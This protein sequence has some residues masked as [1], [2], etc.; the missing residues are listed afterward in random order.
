MGSNIFD[1]LAMQYVL[2][3]SDEDTST[4]QQAAIAIEKPAKSTPAGDN[5]TAVRQWVASINRWMPNG[6]IDDGEDDIIARAQALNFL[7]KTLGFLQKDTLRAD[8]V[9]LLISFFN[10]L[11]S[12]DHKA[13]IAASAKALQQ[14]VTM[15]TFKPS[16]G[17]DIIMN[18]I[19]LGEDFKRQ[20]PAT[21]LEIYELILALLLDPLVA[22]DLSYQHGNTCG[23]MTALVDLCK[24]ERDPQ[25]LI[26]W[27]QIQRLFLQNFAPTDEVTVEVFKAF[28]GYFPITLR[29]SATPSGITVE[30]LKRAVRS[31]FAA[32][33][34]IANLAV[35]FLINKLDQGEAVSVS[36]K[37]DIL[38][39]L[40]ACLRQYEHVKQGIVPYADQ[41][42][43]SLKYE[44]RNGEIQDTI[45]A[46]LKAIGTL[47]NRLDEEDLQAF[48]ATAWADLSEDLAN[49]TY[50]A[51][52]GR[53]LTAIAGSSHKS[54]A[55]TS[56]PAVAQITDT[57][58]HS[59]STSHQAELLTLLNAMLLVRSAFTRDTSGL[60][61]D[62]LFGN[63][64]FEGIYGRLWTEW[65]QS[66][67][68]TE[69]LSVMYKL[70]DG[71][72]Y[73]T[74]QSTSDGSN[75]RLCSDDVC[76]RIFSW[77]GKPSI[78]CR[79]E[80]KRFLQGSLDN[81]QEEL[82]SA[83][84]LALARVAPS[85]PAGFQQ[86][87]VQFLN[88]I[89]I[90]AET[91]I[92]SLIHGEAVREA[93]KRLAYIGC[94]ATACG[95][96]PIANFV[97]LINALLEG[98]HRLLRVSPHFWTPLIDSIHIAIH[99]SLS[100]LAAKLSDEKL[101]EPDISP[102]TTTEGRE[103]FSGFNSQVNGLPE[104]DQDVLG[105]LDE[106][107]ESL[108]KLGRD[109]SLAYQQ[110]L[111][112]SLFVMVQLYRRFVSLE[113]IESATADTTIGTELIIKDAVIHLS[114]EFDGFNSLYST[115]PQYRYLHQL[116]RLATTVI[117]SF[118]AN[119]QKH[120]RLDENVYLLFQGR[121]K[122][123]DGVVQ[124][125]TLGENWAVIK[126]SH[127]ADVHQ[128]AP[129]VLG[130]IQGLWPTVLEKVYLHQT[131][132][133]LCLILA[134]PDRNVS[135]S[136]RASLDTILTTLSNKFIRSDDLVVDWQRSFT[137]LADGFALV[138]RRAGGG[139]P[140][141]RASLAIIRSIM[142]FLSG[143]ITNYSSGDNANWLL[144][145]V[146]DSLPSEITMGRQLAQC[147]EI[148]V[149]EKE[150]LKKENHALVK[151]L[152]RQWIYQKTV[153][154]Y[155]DR[156]FPAA[157]GVAGP[158]IDD[159]VATNQSVAVIAIVKHLDY[160]IWH[161]DAAQIIRVI[162]RSLQKFGVSKDINNVLAVLL[163]VL[164]QDPEL[165]KQHLT[166]LITHILSIYEMAR[167]VMDTLQH[168]TDPSKD[169]L[170]KRDAAMC[171]KSCLE[172]LKRL[173]G[174]Y[175]TQYLVPHRQIVLRGLS[176]ACG[177]PVREVREA[178][179]VARQAW[180]AF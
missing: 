35:P 153:V 42:W 94:S 111:G 7:A 88:S 79:L 86:L 18:I 56:K 17:N 157:A 124:N 114:S 25:N 47:T 5:R 96:S 72:S 102:D 161:S 20:T 144:H 55:L 12:S 19:K 14:L 91:R 135:E 171:R 85:Y 11:F 133:N 122:T 127:G 93:G 89:T 40:E 130:I 83:A 170:S 36:V 137:H 120:L 119:D 74:T 13:G 77:L 58:K 164:D 163:K 87:L 37:V 146:C 156:C 44:V 142:H 98:L 80:K 147:F 65:T 95:T 178:A 162:I 50:T 24:N 63:A 34:R 109:M 52:A 143:N 48:F 69:R 159:R 113:V 9:K 117:R 154:P 101:K 32:H 64:L 176:V 38:Q 107:S 76:N 172:F 16:S 116:G 81:E 66:T 82:G 53:M 99:E 22:N 150:C 68:S 138:M 6:N 106:A 90:V 60:L 149:S 131:L 174:I 31:C 2:A 8:Q 43:A 46:T 110:F 126:H 177:D 61:Q 112:Y 125:L 78:T 54:F 118:S 21:R 140:D 108:D 27:F 84:S 41:I 103:W 136:N 155:L 158:G 145:I 129:L 4:S 29:A 57:L 169:K 15:K 75:R 100:S 23:F 175:E 141:V 139:G 30:D 166:P 49:P 67:H 3:E 152:N 168:I 167:N 148:L 73:L 1:D 104:I 160:D 173:P 62:E 51:S 151:R 92:P 134:D 115:E 70:V 97:L 128:T 39:T 165:L 28:S 132:P 71:M 45:E 105:N 121:T 180:N 59:K 33:Y 123:P 179:I 26:K 10:S